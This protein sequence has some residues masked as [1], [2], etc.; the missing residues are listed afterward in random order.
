[1]IVNKAQEASIVNDLKIY[2]FLFGVFVAFVILAC[3]AYVLMKSINN[4]LRDKIGNK[5]DSIKN[6]VFFNGTIRVIDICY[7]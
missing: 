2:L 7:I 3:I 1:M 5:L 4:E 6:G